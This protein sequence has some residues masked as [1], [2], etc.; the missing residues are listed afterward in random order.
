MIFRMP[1]VFLWEGYRFF[2]F[3]NEGRPAEGRHIHVRKGGAVAKYWLDPEA[4]L[5]SAWGMSAG[6][7][8]TLG[9]VVE[10]RI[11]FLRSKWDEYFH[12]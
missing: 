11:E 10:E 9:K 1:T 4:R 3:S 7:L 6:E 2:F 8:K 12:G 5:A